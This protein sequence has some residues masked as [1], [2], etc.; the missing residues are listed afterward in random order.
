[1]KTTPERAFAIEEPH[2]LSR[3]D[4][5]ERLRAGGDGLTAAEARARRDAVGANALDDPPTDPLWKKFLRSFTDRMIIILLVAAVVSAVVAQE[6]ETPI[7]ILVVVLANAVINVWQE[8]QAEASL[9]SLAAADTQTSRVLRDGHA[10]EVDDLDIVPG[11]VVLLEAGETVPADGRILDAVALEV[12]EAALTGE[13]SPTEKDAAAQVAAHAGLGDRHNM[14]FRSTTLT[15]GRARML[16]TAT[17]MDTEIGQVAALIAGAAPSKTPLQRRIEQLATTLTLIALGVVVVVFALGLIRGIGLKEL[18]LTGVSLAVATIPEG[19]TAVVAFTLAMGATRLARR[20]AILRRLSAVETLGSTTQI[21]TDKTGTLTLNEMT[22]TRLSARG[23][24]FSV[25]GQGYDIDG[26]VRVDDGGAGLDAARE[27]SDA[28]AVF[29]LCADAEVRDGRLVGD[30]TEGALVV[31]AAKLGVDAREARQRRPRVAELPFDATYKLMATYHAREDGAVDVYVKGALGSLAHFADRASTGD[32]R[33]IELDERSRGLLR[34][35]TDSYAQQGLRTMVVA[36]GVLDAVDATAEPRDLLL[37]LPPLELLALIGIV[38][39]PRPAAAAAIAGA[40]RAGIRVQMITGDNATT[41]AAIAGQLGLRGDV[42][43]GAELR[44]L[45]ADALAERVPGLGVLARVSP[46]DKIRVVSAFQSRGEIVAMTG[47]GVN[48]ALALRKADIGVAMGRTGTDVAKSASAMVLT[49]DNIGT[50]L[51]AIREGRGIY[52]NIVRFLTFQLTT[53]WGFLLIFLVAAFTG[54]A[55]GAPFTAI[56]I[57]LVNLV[58]DGPP[59][60]A[61]AV[62]E[63]DDKIMLRAP[64]ATS[65]PLLTWRRGLSIGVRAA[66]MALGTLAIL[67]FGPADPQTGHPSPATTTLAFT[68]F[69][70]FQVFNFLNVRAGSGSVFSKRMLANRASWIAL[71]AVALL[72]VAIVYV[73]PLQAFFDTAA[74]S[75][76]D[77]LIAVGIASLVLWF[78][79]IAKAVRRLGDRRTD[80]DAISA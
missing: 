72:Q 68:T 24:E 6:W 3:A 50:I 43:T 40:D 62:E 37:G 8:H 58:M 4:V 61:L 71:G 64:R 51:R 7:A 30:P 27:L 31:L 73:P 25:D 69:V 11:D 78:D 36:R 21:C 41:A 46:E 74:L 76:V 48:D 70:L 20:G 34:E 77:W 9:R 80:A 12:Q 10:E 5:Q 75:A 14:L 28:A 1:M 56:Q 19:V 45:D 66:L 42:A 23:R 22:A 39:P 49:D 16:V 63:P 57:L 17:G 65:E 18:V 15:R 2:T 32:G 13:S 35:R 29:A 44:D 54:L 67:A 59:A 33:T 60:L 52:D 47:D 55:A 38:D 53:S 26:A 79:E